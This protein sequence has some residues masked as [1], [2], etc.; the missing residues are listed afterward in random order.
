M[1]RTFFIIAA[2]AALLLASCGSSRDLRLHKSIAGKYNYIHSWDYASPDGVGTMHCDEIGVLVFNPDSTYTD[3]AIQKHYHFLPDSTCD[4]YQMRYY[5]EGEWKVQDGKFLFCEHSENFALSLQPL[6]NAPQVRR[7]FADLIRKQTTPNSQR[8][9]TF[10]I[11]RLDNEEFV[12]SYTDKKGNKTTWDMERANCQPKRYR[13]KPLQ[14]TNLKSYADVAVSYADIYACVDGR[15]WETGLL[16]V[17]LEDDSSTAIF[18]R[19]VSQDL[20]GATVGISPKRYTPTLADVQQAE[21]VLAEVM[22][23]G[24]LTK[25]KSRR[26]HQIKDPHLYNK[27]L[28]KYGFYYNEKEERCVHIEMERGVVVL[29]SYQFM[30]IWDACDNYVYINLNLD[31]H[32]VIRVYSSSYQ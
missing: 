14:V 2:F 3:I 23:D 11:E 22:A 7:D 29:R 27:Y 6:N 9:F 19:A 15:T 26:I 10:D 32:E 16:F 12:W 17:P 25:L 4:R 20:W 21:A 8:W 28:R 30:S 24:V 1:K 31:T 13:V 5:C 18:N